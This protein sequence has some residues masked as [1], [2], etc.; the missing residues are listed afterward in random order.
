MLEERRQWSLSWDC[1]FVLF[2]CLSYLFCSSKTKEKTVGRKSIW[3]REECD[4]MRCDAMQF[5]AQQQK[6]NR[7]KRRSKH[8]RASREER[9][10]ERERG[11]SQRLDSGLNVVS[12]IRLAGNPKMPFCASSIDPLGRTGFFSSIV[13]KVASDGWHIYTGRLSSQIWL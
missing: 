11:Q 6:Q 10:R 9:E 4:A 8:E 7:R 2:V 12:A 13:A 1:R 5:N 3:R